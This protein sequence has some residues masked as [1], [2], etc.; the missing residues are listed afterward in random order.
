MSLTLRRFLLSLLALP[1]SAL[2]TPATVPN[3]PSDKIVSSAKFKDA[4]TVLRA[5]KITY[6]KEQEVYEATGHVEVFR[7][8]DTLFADKITYHQKTDQIVAQGHVRLHDARKNVYFVSYAELTGDLKQGVANEIKAIFADNARMAAQ[9]S[10][11]QDATHNSLDYAVYSPCNLCTNDPKSNPL[12]QLKSRRLVLDES[13]ED[14]THYD[15]TM[16][17]LGVPVLYTPYMRHPGPTVKRRTGFLTPFFGSSKELGLIFGAP[18]FWVV[19]PDKDLTVTPVYT[20]ANPLLMLSYRQQFCRGFWRMDLSTTHSHFK[21]GPLNRE[22]KVERLRGHIDTEALINI[23]R[24]WRAGFN[25]VRALD[26][27]Y[28]RRYKFLG[29]SSETFL[30]SEAYAEHFTERDYGLVEALSFQ[31]LR[32]TDVSSRI[33]FVT[34]SAEWHHIRPLAAWGKVTADTSVLNLQRVNGTRMQRFHAKVGWEKTHIFPLGLVGTLGASLRQDAYHVQAFQFGPNTQDKYTGQ[35]G[36]FFPQLMSNLRLPLVRFF[37]KA[38][39]ILEPI[40]GVVVSPN[41]VTK[42]KIPNEDSNLF[43]FD[44]GNLFSPTRFA[45]LDRL[46]KGSRFNWGLKSILFSQHWG[47]SELFFGQSYAWQRQPEA[48]KNSGVEARLSD[49]VL[50]GTLNYQ[51]YASLSHS[52]LINR[53]SFTAKR[54]ETTLSLGVP[55]FRVA[56]TYA[57]LPKISQPNQSS[58]QIHWD[59][60]SQFTQFWTANIFASRELGKSG[61]RLSHGAGVKYEDECFQLH[62]TVAKNYYEDRDL[63]PGVALMCRLVFKNLGAAA[64]SGE[65][66][67]LTKRS[68]SKKNATN[69]G[70]TNLTQKGI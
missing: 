49:Y 21:K 16:E 60:S 15:T 8:G 1:V 31:G 38:R 30:K 12:W 10:K 24:Q 62:L 34:P 65:Q 47:N 7:G 13:T 37:E 56:T 63:K 69:P 53:R 2:A 70:D 18:Y 41:N 51:S 55:I 32:S 19:A 64:F 39:L 17:F 4:V 67:G 9:R 66:L 33:P 59:V 20:K 58:E 23:N 36:R 28:P 44:D 57:L 29:Y 46:D 61:G 54:N 14:V 22:R 50:R 25:I 3:T 26:D 52:A 11:R 42:R 5:D 35:Q 6:H 45:G 48:F 68:A 43:E 40:I 27:P